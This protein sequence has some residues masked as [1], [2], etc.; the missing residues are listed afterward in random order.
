MISRTASCVLL[1]LAAPVLSAA[2]DQDSVTLPLNQL[3]LGQV[4]LFGTPIT[5]LSVGSIGIDSHSGGS[6]VPAKGD[7]PYYFAIPSQK[8]ASGATG[9]LI[10]IPLGND[11]PR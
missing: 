2:G 8:P 7:D 4:K 6:Y 10:R 3:S 11:G 5:G 1:V 9:F